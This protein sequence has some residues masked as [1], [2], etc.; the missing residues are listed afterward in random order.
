MGEE[1]SEGPGAWCGLRVA[2]AAAVLAVSLPDPLP[3]QAVQGAGTALPA[4]SGD[5]LRAEGGSMVLALL[6]SLFV[7]GLGQY[8]DG[9][10]LAGAGYTA[11]AAGG[12]ALSRVGDPSPAA[13]DGRD[14]LA[15]EGLH[16][17]TTSAM[18]SAWDAFR[19]AVPDERSGTEYEFLTSDE[20]LGE[21]LWAPFDPGFLERPTTWINLAFT[22]VV[23]GVILARREPHREYEPFE[24]HDGA[25]VGALSYNAA[26]GEEALFRGWLLPLLHEK[27]GR[28]F[29]VAN[30]LQATAFGAAHVPN[31]DDAAWIIGA[32]A[33]WEGWLTRR[34]DWSIRESIFHHFWYDV[35]V[36]G[37]SFLAD[38]RNAVPVGVRIAF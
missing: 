21:L 14:Q 33:L 18:L 26:M 27:L 5:S 15:F 36:A 20:N 4:R 10:W 13:R 32:W 25:F 17:H 1:R 30:G 28:R 9:G 29:W 31:A 8:L 7:P 11:V 23:T 35:F 19:R 2:A 34:N 22:G 37:A 16:L 6:G 12:L 24:A 38:E 3:A